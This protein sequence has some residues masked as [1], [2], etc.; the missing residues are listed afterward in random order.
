MCRNMNGSRW[1][2]KVLARYLK[3]E[4][5]P[6]AENLHIRRTALRDRFPRSNVARLDSNAIWHMSDRDRC[7]RDEMDMI[8][9]SDG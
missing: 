4:Q 1:E 3:T 2:M 5:L 9:R 8:T 7:P 6:R